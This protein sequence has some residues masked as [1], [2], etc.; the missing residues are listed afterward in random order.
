MKAN[1]MSVKMIDHR[2]DIL[3]FLA[4]NR[5]HL[6]ELIR[7]IQ[8]LRNKLDIEHSSSEWNEINDDYNKSLYQTFLDEMCDKTNIPI[9]DLYT[10]LEDLDLNSFFEPDN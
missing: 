6:K 8:I 3:D 1:S 2:S 7:P 4:K 9:E 5:D 10:E